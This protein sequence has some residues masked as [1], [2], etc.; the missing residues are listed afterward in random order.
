VTCRVK[1]MNIQLES[2]AY[3]FP[4]GHRILV[5][6]SSADFQNALPVS[7]NAVNALHHSRRYPSRVFLPVAPEQN[8]KLPPAHARAV[9]QSI[10]KDGEHP[11]PEKVLTYDLINRMTRISV[12]KPPELSTFSVS[13][14]DPDN[15]VAKSV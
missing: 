14:G 2:M 7:K 6:V 8:P 4:A 10:A 9:A 15:V 11:K 13:D 5:D 12:G 3:I 1:A